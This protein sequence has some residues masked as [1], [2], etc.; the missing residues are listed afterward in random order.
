MSDPPPLPAPRSDLARFLVSL[1]DQGHAVVGATPPEF[2]AAEAVPVLRIIAARASDAMS[3][4][5]PPLDPD[6]AVWAAHRL[7]LLAQAVAVPDLDAAPVVA[8]CHE[9]CPSPRSPATDWSVDLTF[10]HLPALIRLARLRS[11]A[12][13]ILLPMLELARDWPLSSVG[14]TEIPGSLDSFVGHPALLRL[15][16]DRVLAEGDP[17]RLGDS[18]VA[19]RLQADLGLHTELAPRFASRLFDPPP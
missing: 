19:S 9:P 10:R 13:P 6:A 12:D 17:S 7:Y 1:A 16:A 2:D 15:Y 3:L 8:A 11:L 18:R 4:P 5:P 14:S